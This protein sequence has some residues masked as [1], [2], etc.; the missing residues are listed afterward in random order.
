MREGAVRFR[1]A[2]RVFALLHRVAAVLRSVRELGR[3]ALAR[4]C[5]R[6]GNTDQRA[7]GQCM[8]LLCV[9]PAEIT[10]ADYGR[11]NVCHGHSVGAGCPGPLCRTRQHA[12]EVPP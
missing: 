8:P 2:V 7:S 6:I 4:L 12:A 3:E 5:E 9:K 10:A 1:H 11:P